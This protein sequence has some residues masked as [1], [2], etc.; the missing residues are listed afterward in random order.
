MKIFYLQ[1][2]WGQICLWNRWGRWGHRWG[3]WGHRWSHG[4]RWGHGG[5]PIIHWGHK[6]PKVQVSQSGPSQI[7]QP[8]N[9]ISTMHQKWHWMSQGHL[10]LMSCLRTAKN[11][12]GP[13][14]SNSWIEK[15]QKIGQDIFS[16]L[17]YLWI[18]L[19]PV[20]SMVWLN[21]IKSYLLK[22]ACIIMIYI[23]TL[24]VFNGITRCVWK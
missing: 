5:N 6:S 4:C 12:W 11:L 15:M 16:A 17:K 7:F 10:N 3:R 23:R 19:G 1:N 14:G 13:E 21:V 22:V 8:L 2:V 24:C 20:L 18:V 9:S